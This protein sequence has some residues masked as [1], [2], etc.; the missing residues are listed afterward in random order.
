MLTAHTGAQ[1]RVRLTAGR[2]V[3]AAQPAARVLRLRNAKGSP[4]SCLRR[5][6]PSAGHLQRPLASSRPN[7]RASS[8]VSVVDEVHAGI[9]LANAI[10]TRFAVPDGVVVTPAPP[11]ATDNG[12]SAARRRH[13]HAMQPT[14][15]PLVAVKRDGWRQIA[16]GG[17]A[18]FH[19]PAAPRGAPGRHRR[20]DPVPWLAKRGL[21]VGSYA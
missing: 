19:R 9:D 1:R 18:A 12:V 17:H 16:M 2:Q 4:G 3:I 14:S 7:E 15:I 13:G 20:V 11:P 21:S 5:G 10:G 6:A 8:S